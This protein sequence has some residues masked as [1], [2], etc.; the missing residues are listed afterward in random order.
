MSTFVPGEWKQK[1]Y[2]ADGTKCIKYI[3]K[4]MDEYIYI[5][6]YIKGIWQTLLSK[7]TYNKYICSKRQQY[8]TVVHKDKNR[9]G[10][11]HSQ[12]NKTASSPSNNW[13]SP[14][15]SFFIF[16]SSNKT[17]LYFKNTNT[18]RHRHSSFATIFCLFVRSFVRSFVR[19]GPKQ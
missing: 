18:A 4:Q 17:K 13:G 19:R 12:T 6:I 7:A 2:I 11:N 8:I 5:C 9:A 1:Q 10:F 14:K 16:K 3:S 15:T